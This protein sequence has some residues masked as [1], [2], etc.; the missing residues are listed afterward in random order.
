[1]STVRSNSSDSGVTIKDCPQNMKENIPETLRTDALSTDNGS[2]RMNRTSPPPAYESTAGTASPTNSI[3]SQNISIVT[4]DENAD[5]SSLADSDSDVE[6][7]HIGPDFTVE[8]ILAQKSGGTTNGIILVS[9]QC[10]P[11]ISHP[12]PLSSSEVKPNIGSIAV[13]NSS[14]ITFGNKTFYQGPVTIKQFL[15]ENNKWRPSAGAEGNDNPG[16]VNTSNVNL[17]GNDGKARDFF[18]RKIQKKTF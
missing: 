14:D 8:N 11:A 12:G 17:N 7:V 5:D 2:P 4:L 16:F 3:S 10:E 9:N 18:F 1:M 13:Q 15:Y 6:D